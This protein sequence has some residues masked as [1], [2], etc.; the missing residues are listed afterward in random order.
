MALRYRIPSVFFIVSGAFF[1]LTLFLSLFFEK[2]ELHL[3]LNRWRHPL[4]DWFFKYSTHLGDGLIFVPAIVYLGIRRHTDKAVILLIVALMTLLITALGK[5]VLF[6]AV[7]RPVLA[8]GAENLNLVDGVRMHSKFSFPSG[9][10][11]A[12][13]AFWATIAAFSARH[14]AYIFAFIAVAVAVSRVYLS[15][16]FVPDVAAGCL[17]G[18]MIAAFS[19]RLSHYFPSKT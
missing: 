14:L 6:P 1:V 10:T 5:S 7:N 4:A 9:H 19:V 17:I 8:I 11:T 16:H 2:I 15:Q 18:T 12:A 3:W 13:F